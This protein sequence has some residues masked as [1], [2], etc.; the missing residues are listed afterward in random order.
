MYHVQRHTSSKIFGTKTNLAERKI[1][2]KVTQREKLF[3]KEKKIQYAFSIE[4]YSEQG[5]IN[6]ISEKKIEKS[7]YNRKTGKKNILTLSTMNHTNVL[8]NIHTVLEAYVYYYDYYYC[9]LSFK[10]YLFD[11]ILE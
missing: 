3:K 5:Q 9:T 6:N 1:V 2:S 10:V 4:T 11:S 7:K 8:K